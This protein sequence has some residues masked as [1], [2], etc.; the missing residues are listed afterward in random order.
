MDHEMLLHTD[1]HQVLIS[2]VDRVLSFDRATGSISSSHTPQTDHILKNN[3]GVHVFG[4]LGTMQLS[5]ANYLFVIAD[6]LKV[7]TLSTHEVHLIKNVDFVNISNKPTTDADIRYLT[8]LRR[9]F[10]SQGFYYSKTMD[11]TT[12]LKA[13]YLSG[14]KLNK[15]DEAFWWN[16][17]ISKSIIDA[18]YQ[19]WVHPIIRG[20]K[21]LALDVVEFH[22]VNL[23]HDTFQFGIISRL[24]CKRVGTRY[25]TRGADKLGNVANYVETEQIVHHKNNLLSFLQVRGSIPLRWTQRTNLKYKPKLVLST[26]V[27][28]IFQIHI[29]NQM[30]RYSKIKIINL[31]NQEGS[32]NL[33]GDKFKAAHQELNHGPDLKYLAF[34]FHNKTKLTNFDGILELM[35]SVKDELSDFGYTRINLDGCVTDK[36][37]QGVLR[38]N[39]IDCLDRTNVCE[40]VFGRMVLDEQLHH[41][42]I[43]KDDHQHV[44]DEPLIEQ[45]FK[46][47]WAD[48]GDALSNLYAGTNAIKADFTRTGKRTLRG[49]INDGINSLRRYYLNNFKDGEKQDG[50][51]LLLGRVV[52]KDNNELSESQKTATQLRFYIG[53]ATISA[54]VYC[55]IKK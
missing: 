3:K 8:L 34:D 47:V 29:K 23:D 13:W 45:L 48:N 30:D 20:C 53:L 11:L 22:Q 25:N 42:H 21:L 37:Q 43:F 36:T 51:N 28:N 24:G 41:L 4:V 39:C 33:I 50:L 5:S 55:S 10:T 12:H 38:V 2:S 31:I 49:L 44:K 26:P 40:S 32:E 18:G 19:Y 9:T 15:P 16:R 27:E 14:R 6:Q 52:I 54:L 1:K 7:G 46:N 35:N 17:H